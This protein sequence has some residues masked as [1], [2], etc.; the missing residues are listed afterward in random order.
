MDTW[1]IVDSERAA[2][3]ELAD[4]LT[5][6]QWDQQSL[7]NQWKVRDVV[8]HV[9]EGASLT[10]VQAVLGLMKYGFRLNTMLEREAIKDGAAPPAALGK[11]LHD[12]VGKRKTPPGVKAVGML[13]DTVVHQQDV[14][15][16]L[17]VPRQVPPE[18]LTIALDEMAKQKTG[19]LPGKK[20]IDGLKLRA[21]DVAWEHGEGDEVSGP[22][23]SL[24]M[25]MAGRPVALADLSGPG[26]D[27]LRSRVGG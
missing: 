13:L 2:F 4:S 22:G 16:P 5:P 26:L 19:L 15:R 3:A 27:T 12:T 24:L 20:R 21:T 8:A 6:E 23:E 17:N 11:E 9:N 1:E 25:A 7:C 10:G 14:R 18:T